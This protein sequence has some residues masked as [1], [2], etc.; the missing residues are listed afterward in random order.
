MLPRTVSP[1]ICYHI[2]TLS[3]LKELFSF[4][5]LYIFVIVVQSSNQAGHLFDVQFSDIY[6]A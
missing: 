5:I 3:R 2:G 1:L 4:E 6:L